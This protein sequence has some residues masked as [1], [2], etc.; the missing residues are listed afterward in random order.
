[1]PVMSVNEET[2]ISETLRLLTPLNL[3][4]VLQNRK[5]HCFADKGFSKA[6]VYIVLDGAGRMLAIQ[7][8]AFSADYPWSGQI[9]FPGGHVEPGDVSLLAA[10]CRELQ[11]EVGVSDASL[12]TVG[13]LGLFPT[14]SNVSIEAFVGFACGALRL[15]PQ[16]SEVARILWVDIAGLLRC[17]L[18]NG[19]YNRDVAVSD[20]LY[21][22]DDVTIWGATARIIQFLLDMALDHVESVV[23]KA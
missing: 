3:P 4:G 19:Y 10:A 22:V 12:H 20:L 14:I 16:T 21:P 9:A 1:M 11:E 5:P 7:K 17:H 18:L 6:A 13:S 8:P 23:Q 15:T 2:L